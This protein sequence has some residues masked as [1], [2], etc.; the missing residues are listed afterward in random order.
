VPVAGD[1]EADGDAFGVGFGDVCGDALTASCAM[2]MWRTRNKATDAI[3]RFFIC[4]IWK[5]LG[6]DFHG[7]PFTNRVNERTSG[8]VHDLPCRD[9]SE[10]E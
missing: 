4:L 5:L 8:G 6:K 3:K 10:G 1:A 2:E 7:M 9:S